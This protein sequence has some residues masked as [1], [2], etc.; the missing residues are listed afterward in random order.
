VT[1]TAPQPAFRWVVLI[2]AAVI[3]ALSMG[4]LI[5]G[6]TVFFVPLE[7]EFG[8]QRGD[9]ALI[10]TFGLIG[11][12]VGGIV[13]GRLADR[14]GTLRICL[15][16]AAVLGLCVLASAYANRL[17]QF[18]A[19]FLVAGAMGGAAFFA[20]VVALVG[21][22][23]KTGAGLALG[24][25]S[26]GQAVGQGGI[27]LAA[28][29]LIAEFGWRGALTG[30]GAA[31][32]AVVVPLVFLMRQP[33]HTGGPV[34]AVDDTPPVGNL[35]H[36][37]VV[38]TISVAVVGCCTLMAVP[39]MHLFPLM[40]GRGIAAADA[41][42]VMLAMLT[43][44][45]AGR[46]FFGKL[47]DMIGAL[48]AYMTASV[49][50]TVM[51]FGFTQ[52]QALDSFYLYA[53]LYGFGYSGVMTGILTTTRVLTRPSRR[54]S[55]MGVIGAFAFVGHGIGGWQ[56]GMLFDLTGD[57]SLPY[58]VAAAAGVFNL[59]VVSTLVMRLRRR[60]LAQPA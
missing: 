7:K 11:L 8:W 10:N 56:A 59:L 35:P 45:V 1:D 25:V 44:G 33:P 30:L 17:W 51:V 48:P 37:V 55:A 27:P 18:Y 39:L 19:L 26:A 23:F 13:M 28:A 43:V 49:W 60:R 3:L 32:L 36:G 20:P 52:F 5:N 21:N 42:G 15:T 41:G 50:Q 38:V 24:I 53:A 9:I 4:L 14:F 2:A 12:A 40:Q 34:G 29:M 16:G 47:A 58:A 46:V 54:G 57:Y 22:W 6:L 31:I